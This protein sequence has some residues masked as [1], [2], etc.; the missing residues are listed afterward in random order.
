MFAM[1]PFPVYNYILNY[2]ETIRN[3]VARQDHRTTIAVTV[4]SNIIIMFGLIYF[5]RKARQSHAKQ[6]KNSRVLREK[7]VALRQ[8][9]A[10]VKSKL[11][12]LREASNAS[13]VKLSELQEFSDLLNVQLAELQALRTEKEKEIVQTKHSYDARASERKREYDAQL[14]EKDKEIRELKTQVAELSKVTD[15]NFLEKIKFEQA[16]Q[17]ASVLTSRL[18]DV[19]NLYPENTE[20]ARQ[21]AELAAHFGGQIELKTTRKRPKRAAAPK[22]FK[23]KD[24]SDDEA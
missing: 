21:L 17:I 16:E 22:S 7:T 20:L 23:P 15:Q 11:L 2:W 18:I 9:I 19:I 3:F 12:E 6:I 14:A 4:C 1:N 24:D 8:K 13:D 10:V 5:Y